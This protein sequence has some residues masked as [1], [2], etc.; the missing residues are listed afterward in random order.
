[1]GLWIV[2]VE[3]RDNLRY[4]IVKRFWNRL[5]VVNSWPSDLHKGLPLCGY[6]GQGREEAMGLLVVDEGPQSRILNNRTGVVEFSMQ[7]SSLPFSGIRV[8]D[9]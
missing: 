7:W 2:Q 4:K 8:L 9:Q 1:M 3:M 6:L 5:A